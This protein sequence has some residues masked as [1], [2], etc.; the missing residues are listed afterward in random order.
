MSVTVTCKYC[1][2]GGLHSSES[3]EGHIAPKKR[4]TGSRGKLWGVY[5]I[6]SLLIKQNKCFHY[7]FLIMNH[8]KTKKDNFPLKGHIFA[9]PNRVANSMRDSTPHF[10]NKLVIF[11]GHI[12]SGCF[13]KS[14]TWLLIGEECCFQTITFFKINLISKSLELHSEPQWAICS[15]QTVCCACLQ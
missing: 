13:Q 6:T 15:L 10:G 8:R 3:G 11:C 5:F 9:F 12:R 14:S 4:A 2:R 7:L 1:S